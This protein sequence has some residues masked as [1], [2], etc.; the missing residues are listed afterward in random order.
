MVEIIE[1]IKAF[2]EILSTIDDE[3]SQLHQQL[4]QCDLESSDLLHEIELSKF[5]A[6]E[7]YLLAK[8]LQEV[9]RR[10]REIKNTQEILQCIKDF[11]GN[12]KNLAI[13]LYKLIKSMEEKLEIQQSRVYVPRVRQDIKLAREAI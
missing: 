8:K 12:N 3:W 4:Q 2:A 11:A 7:G 13:A 9:R 5:N 10:R 1:K 6:C